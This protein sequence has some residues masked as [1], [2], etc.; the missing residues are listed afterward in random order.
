MVTAFFS[1]G[2]ILFSPSVGRLNTLYAYRPG[3]LVDETVNAIIAPG[4]TPSHRDTPIDIND[5]HVVHAHEGALRKT[6]KQLGVTL[7]G[8]LH[9]CKGCSIAKG[10]LMP[11]PSKTNRRGDKRLLSRVFVNLGGNKHMTSMGGNKY[12]M[13]TRDNFSRYAWLYLISHKSDTTEAFKQFL[14]YLIVGGIP[15]EAVVVRSDNGG[16]FN[17][18]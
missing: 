2:D 1:T 11:I 10:Y 8:K 12:P 3:M 14:A 9:R 15:S 16:E 4:L 18:G 6:A 13:I 17:K 5:F 7:E